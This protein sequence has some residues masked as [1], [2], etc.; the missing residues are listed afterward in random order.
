MENNK[1]CVYVDGHRFADNMDLD[2]AMI[3]VKA[4]FKEYYEEHGMQICIQE[5]DRVDNG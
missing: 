1:Y 3:V 4:L 2:V 5:M